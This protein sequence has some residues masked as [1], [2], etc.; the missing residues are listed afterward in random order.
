[1]SKVTP[2]IPAG[3]ME[4]LPGD[5][6]QFNKMLE[7]IGG[8][9]ERFGFTPLD[10]PAM[11]HL[12]VL[13]A[14]SGGETD[15]QVY[16]IVKK[17]K[18]NNEYCLHTDL[19]IPLARYVAMNQNDLTFPFKRYQMQKVWRGE[20]PQRGRFREFYQCDIDVVGTSNPIVDAEIPSVIYSVF[21]ELGFDRFTIRINNRKVLNGFLASLNLLEQSKDVLSAIDKLEKLG[22]ETVESELQACNIPPDKIDKIFQFVA[23][24]GATE[25][26]ISQLEAL[27]IE[28]EV[29]VQGLSNLSLVARYMEKLGIP[30]SNYKIDLS[31]A[32]GLDY[33]T[34]TVYETQ[35]DDYPQI[36]SVCSGGRYDDLAGYYT[37]TELPGV[38]ISIGLTRLFYQFKAAGLIPTGPSTP[39]DAIV[40]PNDENCIDWAIEV[41]S[42]LRQSGI[43]TDLYLEQNTF[44]K[45][46]KYAVNLKVPFVVI[47]GEDAVLSQNLILK[48]ME[49]GIQEAVS[50]DA[51]ICQILG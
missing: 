33:Y 51:A 5:Q 25:E 41:T 18:S 14:K 28:D 38:G 8:V 31:I 46:F 40:I 4:L 23:I 10:T 15:K 39:A 17:G 13:L 27:G 2:R 32:R 24:K 44:K 30:T 16:R 3:F 36:G 43:N 49:S 12:E 42:A 45:K 19:T 21:K 9:Y 26:I 20:R 22:K 1:M 7:I 11:E 29:F 35:L 34:G 48:D 6:I 47:I 50:V 37:D